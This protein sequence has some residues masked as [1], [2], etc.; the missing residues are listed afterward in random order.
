MKVKSEM[1]LEEL[2]S[3]SYV[4]HGV[5]IVALIQQLIG[6]Q[7]I[8]DTEL[9][10]RSFRTES[11]RIMGAF[12][13]ELLIGMTMSTLKLHAT[14]HELYVDDVVVDAAYRGQGFGSLLMHDLESFAGKRGCTAVMLTSSRE[15]A[16]EF[17]LRRG[18]LTTTRAFKKTI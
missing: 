7:K 8:V 15:E 10:Q 12:A 1:R 3:A 6:P 11:T 9:V 2:S 14:G 18:Y 4:L 5:R 17:Y 16:Q 13:G